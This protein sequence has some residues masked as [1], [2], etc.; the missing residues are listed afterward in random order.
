MVSVTTCSACGRP[1]HGADEPVCPARR[2]RGEFVLWGTHPAYGNVPIKISGG[3]A[4]E[5]R[6]ELRRRKSDGGWSSLEIKAAE[7]GGSA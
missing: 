4:R 3:T 2:T 5:C 7:I 1:G 6:G